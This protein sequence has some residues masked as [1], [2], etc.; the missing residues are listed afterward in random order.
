M[1]M[2]LCL[3]TLN[4]DF[5]RDGYGRGPVASG[6]ILVA[7]FSV[8]ALYFATDANAQSSKTFNLPFRSLRRIANRRRVEEREGCCLGYLLQTLPRFGF[9]PPAFFFSEAIGTFSSDLCGRSSWQWA[10]YCWQMCVLFTKDDEPVEALLPDGLNESF[11]E[12]VSCSAR[13]KQRSKVLAVSQGYTANC[14]RWLSFLG[15][16]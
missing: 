8:A 6:V 13:G 1:A 15:F 5:Y 12:G 10:R 11:D 14:S 9:R 2:I 3:R 16:N 7:L 4:V